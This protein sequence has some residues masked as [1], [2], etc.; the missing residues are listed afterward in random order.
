[1]LSA[2]SGDGKVDMTDFGILCGKWLADDCDASNLWCDRAD[3]NQSGDVGMEDLAQMVADWVEG[4]VWDD[5]NQFDLDLDFTFRSIALPETLQLLN[6]ECEDAI[7][8]TSDTEYFGSTQTAT[9]TTPFSCEASALYDVWYNFIPEQDGLYKVHV[10]S[11][12][13][14]SSCVAIYSDCAGSELHCWGRNDPDRYFEAT[15]GTSYLI[16]IADYGS[17]RGDFR[18]TVIYYPTPAND[19]CSEALPVEMGQYYPGETYGATGNSASSCGWDDTKDVWYKYTAVDDGTIVF[20]FYQYEYDGPYLTAAVFDGCDGTEL[21]CAVYMGTGEG[22]PE[23]ILVLEDAQQGQTYYIRVAR[24]DFNYGKFD[25]YVEPGPENDECT[26][27]ESIDVG[28]DTA[29]STIGATGSDITSCGSDDSRDIWYSLTSSENQT[30]LI[31]VSDYSFSWMFYTVSIFDSCGGSEQACIE[32]SE[33]G[34][35]MEMTAQ[36]VYEMSLGETVYIRVAYNDD[37]MGRFDLN[38]SQIEVPYNDEC[39]DAEAVDGYTSGSTLGATGSDESS[40]GEN[41]THDVWYTFTPETTDTYSIGIHQEEGSFEGTISVYDGD[42]CDPLPM[43]LGCEQTSEWEDAE[44]Y[45]ELT[46]EVTYLIRVASDDAGQ[47]S[48]GLDIYSGGG[49]G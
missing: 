3:I 10:E 21:A 17:S 2:I 23:T 12:G 47:G 27:A 7:V 1:M 31:R 34:G 33:G 29:G 35:E 16:R 42:S 18:F 44:L 4:N 24:D 5:D 13:S 22:D 39:V 25:L 45:I 20:T 19:E 14:F 36:I 37:A 28:D 15:A 48:F 40:C 6:D 38:I 43:E 8:I 26:D 49:P 9:G 46:A 41:D 30:V 32:S 11:T